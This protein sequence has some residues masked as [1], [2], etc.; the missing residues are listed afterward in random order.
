MYGSYVD[1]LI[2]VNDVIIITT[3]CFCM[4]VY[5]EVAISYSSIHVLF[6]LHIVRSYLVGQVSV[7]CYI[8]CRQ[9]IPLLVLH[10]HH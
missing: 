2:V 3:C 7:H 6:F 1:T 4:T 9:L 5:T 8:V 10:N